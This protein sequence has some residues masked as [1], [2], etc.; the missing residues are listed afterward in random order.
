M[1]SKR[2]NQNDKLTHEKYITLKAADLL[3]FQVEYKIVFEENQNIM[4]YVTQ[5]LKGILQ[6]RNIT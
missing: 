3:S 6:N 2:I 5:S 4:L 1:L